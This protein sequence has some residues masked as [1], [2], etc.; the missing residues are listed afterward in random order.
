MENQLDRPQSNAEHSGE[1][2]IPVSCRAEFLNHSG[3][4]QPLPRILINFVEY[5]MD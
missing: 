1:G 4:V 2:K 3:T 5:N